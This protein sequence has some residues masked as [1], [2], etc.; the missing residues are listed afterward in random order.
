TFRAGLTPGRKRAGRCSASS[1]APPHLRYASAAKTSPQN[2]AQQ[3][4]WQVSLWP[5]NG[6]LGVRAN[7]RLSRPRTALGVSV[8]AGDPDGF[9]TGT[10]GK[11]P[12]G[13]SP[14]AQSGFHDRRRPSKIL[15]ARRRLAGS[16][17]YATRDRLGKKEGGRIAT[18]TNPPERSMP[19]VDITG[20]DFSHMSHC[21]FPETLKLCFS[22]GHRQLGRFGRKISRVTCS[23]L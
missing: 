19:T 2:L 23:E 4:G 11:P 6:F 14:G 9:G 7:S 10:F 16:A 22:V 18:G 1:A 17:R 13:V 12:D 20:V 3:Q 15:P 8:A 21:R 5:Q